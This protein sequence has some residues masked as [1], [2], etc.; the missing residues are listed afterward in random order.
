MERGNGNDAGASSAAPVPDVVRGADRRL[1]MVPVAQLTPCKRNARKHSRKQ[2]RHIADSIQAFGYTCPVLI[3]EANEILAGHG[4]VA[5]AKLLGLPEVPAL[6]IG[7]LSPAQ[8]RAYLIA[9]N[10]IAA[11]AGW[12]RQV[13]ALELQALIDI[14]FEVSLTGF[15]M[16]EIQIILDGAEQARQDDAE[17]EPPRSAPCPSVSG[18]GDQWLLGE[19]WLVCGNASDDYAAVDAAIRQWQ[20]SSG[21]AATLYGGTKTFDAV[22]QERRRVRAPKPRARTANRDTV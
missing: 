8:K 5:A 21:K 20:R 16:E 19:H 11:K 6:R 3:D 18:A 17:A 1:E 13:L 4:R 12:D 22:E 9:D 10:A 7:H 2:I 15:E 14:D